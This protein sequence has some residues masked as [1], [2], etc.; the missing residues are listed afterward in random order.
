[1]IDAP[2]TL[3]VDAFWISP[4]ALSAFVALEEKGLP[5]TTVEL[6]LAT[7]DHQKPGYAART[8]RVPSLQHGDY[9][10]SESSAIAEYLAETFPFPKYPRLFPENLQ[11]RGIAREIMAWVRSDLMPIREERSTT[12][13]FYERA[14]RPL[15]AAGE[16]AKQRLIDAVTPLIRGTT[17]FDAWCLADTDLAV[18]LQRLNLNGDSLPPALKT[19]AEA[20]WQRPSVQKWVSRVRKPYQ[21]Y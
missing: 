3:C 13:M 6:N 19:Y 2:L 10:L 21:T 4:Y 8:G 16:K 1:M 14:A 12:S 11:Q 5:Y 18:M 17:L 9:V 20:N 15:S 7:K